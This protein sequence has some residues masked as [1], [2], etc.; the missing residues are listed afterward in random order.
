MDH[1]TRSSLNC[2]ASGAIERLSGFRTDEQWVADQIKADTSRFVPVW[3]SMNLFE[4]NGSHPGF[5]TH[6]QLNGMM[7]VESKP[8]LLGQ[9]DQTVYFAVE[10]PSDDP[11]IPEQVAKLGRFQDLKTVATRLE[12]QFGVLL[13]YARAMTYWHDQ[14]RFCGLCGFPTL[15]MEGGHLLECSNESCR[16]KH[17]PRTDPAIIVL[18]S[19][20]D[21]CLLGRQPVWPPKWY[22]TIAGFVDPGESLENA[23]VREV[24]EETGVHIADVVYHS[25]QPWPFPSSLMVG[26]TATALNDTIRVD[27]REL[28]HA[29][30]FTRKDIEEGL[31][32]GTLRLPPDVSI[33]YRL[34]EH[35]F[36]RGPHGPLNKIMYPEKHK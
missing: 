16:Q 10:L 2:F 7:G 17:F 32:Q 30:W 29:D 20:K 4:N 36:N 8:I 19:L 23:V 12:N 22:S 14:N 24:Q 15:S 26:F 27:N 21:K 34:I 25:S 33:S 1:Y 6:E 31:K 35:W 3:Q 11:T 28:E 5:L 13:A 9:I 18:V